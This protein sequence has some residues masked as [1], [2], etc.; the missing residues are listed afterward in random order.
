MYL[1]LGDVQRGTIIAHHPQHDN[2]YR[3]DMKRE[4]DDKSVRTYHG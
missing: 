3:T 4:S 2:F 1:P